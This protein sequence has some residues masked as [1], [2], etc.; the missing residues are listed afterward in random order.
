MEPQMITGMPRIAIA[1][2][3]FEAMVHCFDRAF[4]MP[5]VQLPE[6]VVRHLGA[7]LAMC[8]PSGGSNIELMCPANP[9]LPLSQSLSSFLERRGEGLF[10]LML[11]ADDP[12]SAAELFAARG[13]DVLPLMPGAGGRDIHPRSTHGVLIR[14]YP[15]GSFT[16]SA[17]E[18]A[19]ES[20]DAPAH[21]SGLSGIQRVLIAV[22][23]LEAASAVYVEG[24][25]LTAGSEHLNIRYG[26]RSIE[27][28]PPGEQ[29]IIEL[30][31]PV[32]LDKPL[33]R[34]VDQQLSAKGSGLFGLVVTAPDL[35]PALTTLVEAGIGCSE[36]APG[37]ALVEIFGTRIILEQEF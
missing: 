24:L 29:G 26:T 17:T 15:T 11:E 12:D 25:G 37:A 10:A 7:R 20:A 31:T 23:D 3:D 36:V 6:S 14:I 21:T 13:L 1:A 34:L 4:G 33:A 27:V 32:E 18:S 2:H 5:I 9:S 19:T 30:V 35:S 22:E 16:R 28:L 8:V